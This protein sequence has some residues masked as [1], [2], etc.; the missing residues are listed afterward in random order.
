MDQEVG[1]K[2]DKEL[3]SEEEGEMVDKEV[4]KK[5]DRE[6]D[7]KVDNEVDKEEGQVLSSDT[8]G[9]AGRRVPTNQIWKSSSTLVLVLPVA[10]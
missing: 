6:V 9:Q 7:E 4:G 5:V 10:S 8:V 3:D 1:E 2:V